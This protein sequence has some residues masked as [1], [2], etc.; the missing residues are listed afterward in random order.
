MIKLS[1][2]YRVMEENMKKYYHIMDVSKF[3]DVKTF[4]LHAK[5]IKEIQQ[6]LINCKIDSWVVDLTKSYP[7][8]EEINIQSGVIY[9]FF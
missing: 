1:N 2:I 4:F 7:S 6:F 9:L 8:E 5:T 3:P